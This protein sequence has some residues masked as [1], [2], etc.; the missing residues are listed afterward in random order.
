MLLKWDVG[1]GRDQ[2]VF[3]TVCGKR[4]KHGVVGWFTFARS[5][6][7]TKRWKRGRRRKTLPLDL[8]LRWPVCC[9][10]L[11]SCQSSPAETAYGSAVCLKELA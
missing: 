6:T 3:F 9:S 5:R 1:I 7:E 4:Y 8:A 10:M 2:T 11:L